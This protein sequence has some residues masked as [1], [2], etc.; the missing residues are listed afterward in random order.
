MTA[1][2][3]RGKGRRNEPYPLVRVS[4]PAREEWS[5]PLLEEVH[6]VIEYEGLTHVILCSHDPA[7]H[8][9]Q[10]GHCHLRMVLLIVQRPGGNERIGRDWER[11]LRND[12]VL[13]RRVR[14]VEPRVHGWGDQHHRTCRLAETLDDQGCITRGVEQ[15][16]ILVIAGLDDLLGPV[17]TDCV[18]DSLSVVTRTNDVVDALHESR[19][20][21]LLSLPRH[22]HG[23]QPHDGSPLDR[24]RGLYLEEA[25]VV[26]AK[27]VHVIRPDCR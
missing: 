23:G 17:V 13:S 12:L 1:T 8:L 14:E 2:L 6:V 7:C 11:D 9:H 19:E 22:A 27:P 10:T 5:V 24:E 4:P 20:S 18:N 25:V 26:N 21:G 16:A 15:H 3:Q